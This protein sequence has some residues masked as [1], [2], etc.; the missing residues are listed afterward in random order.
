MCVVVVGVVVTLRL[1][2]FDRHFLSTFGDLSGRQRGF[3]VLKK[4]GSRTGFATKMDPKSDTPGFLVF[5]QVLKH[6][7]RHH[8]PRGFVLVMI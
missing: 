3:W 1:H 8:L 6:R 2:F 7:L 4:G 5:E